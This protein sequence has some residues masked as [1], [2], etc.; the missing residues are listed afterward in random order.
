MFLGFDALGHDRRAAALALRP[1]GA[2]DLRD[3]GGW[4]FLDEPQVELDHIGAQQRHERERAHVG[5]HVVERDAPAERSHA[6]HLAEQLGGASGERA[7]GDLDEGPQLARPLP[8]RDE[9]RRARL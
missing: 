8:V 1:D 5:A 3:V 7:L 4:A 2:H 6:R 9:V